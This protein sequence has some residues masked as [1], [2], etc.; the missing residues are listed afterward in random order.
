M[1]TSCTRHKDLLSTAKE[2]EVQTSKSRKTHD[3]WKD[4]T[5]GSFKSVALMLA[6]PF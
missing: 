5:E 4:G 2:H 1:A 6:E 3:K